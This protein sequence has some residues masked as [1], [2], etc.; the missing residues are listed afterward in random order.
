MNVLITGM[1][2][3][4]PLGLGVEA[5]WN[6]LMAGDSA[7]RAYPE[8]RQYNGLGTY[9][10]APVP[11]YDISKIPRSVRRTMS[12]MSEMAVLAAGEA[13]QMA[14][15]PIGNH[16]GNRLSTPRILLCLGSTTGA[17]ET[18]EAYFR[19]LIE[20][21]GPGGSRARAFLRS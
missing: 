2:A 6:R 15:L 16:L 9:L 10:G 12:R 17:P 11:P 18:M 21:G 20:R 4:T 3:I 19:K 14:D 5:T 8:W 1:G 7:I 13:L